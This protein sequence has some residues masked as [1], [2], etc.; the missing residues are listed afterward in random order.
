MKPRVS[1]IIPAYNA[2]KYLRQCLDSVVQQ[3]LEEI[4]IIVVNDGSSDN[5][6]GICRDYAQKYSHLLYLEKENG[7][8]ASARNMGLDYAEGE[9]VGFVDADDWI[10][11]EMYERL[12]RAAIEN[13]GADIVFCRAFEDECAGANNYIF[14][15][16]GYYDRKEME[17]ELFPYILPFVNEKGTFRSIRWTNCLRIYK[18]SVIDKYHIRSCNGIHNCEDLGFTVE[19]TI[20]STSYF[21]MDKCLYHN[22]PNQASQSRN[23]SKN[24]WAYLRK[25]TEYM[26]SYLMACD[27]F[28]FT[29]AMNVCT[30]YFCTM[31]IRNEMRLKS[32]AEQVNNVQRILDDEICRETVKT[33][34]ANGMNKEYS[35]LYELVY[36]GDAEALV[37]YLRALNWRKQKL[38]PMLSKIT[39]VPVVRSLYK[40]VKHQ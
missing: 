34:S 10:E 36:R 14:P 15:R 12:Y 4:Q 13:R 19:C 17:T 6:E 24:M 29:N 28:D 16:Y 26:Q 21:Y 30:F 37:K 1:I 25:L 18:K 40:I 22:R 39:A 35:C 5:T 33:I 2:E 38:A 9:Y 11:P 3:T 31:A 7:G 23:Y 8:S 20:H 32:K 27:R